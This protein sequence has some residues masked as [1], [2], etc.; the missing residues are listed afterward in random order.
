M[1][2]LEDSYHGGGE[3]I[4][5]KRAGEEEMENNGAHDQTSVFL[6]FSTINVH[7]LKKEVP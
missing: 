3:V 4:S 1:Q 6:S 5:K 2:N 7:G